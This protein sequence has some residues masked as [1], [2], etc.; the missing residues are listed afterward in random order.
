MRLLLVNNWT[1]HVMRNR[2]ALVLIL[3]IVSITT[4]PFALSATKLVT[5]YRV[6]RAW[7][8]PTRL[9]V[10]YKEETAKVSGLNGSSKHWSQAYTQEFSSEGFLGVGYSAFG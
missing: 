3:L 10:L 8:D 1:V 2:N 7:F 4:A 9:F 5:T 6:E